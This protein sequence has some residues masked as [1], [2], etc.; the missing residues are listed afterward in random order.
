MSQEFVFHLERPSTFLG[1]HGSEGLLEDYVNEV[2]SHLNINKGE[3]YEKLREIIPDSVS[4][5][6]EGECDY[7]YVK[8]NTSEEAYKI[9]QGFAEK[10]KNLVTNYAKSQDEIKKYG[11]LNFI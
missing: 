7:F 10:F 11:N 6:C 8:G 5:K 9:M 1:L 3:F 2:S 4:V